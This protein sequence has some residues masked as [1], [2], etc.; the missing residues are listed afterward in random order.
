MSK[1]RQIVGSMRFMLNR[2]YSFKAGQYHAMLEDQY[3]GE[4]LDFQD[5]EFKRNS[6]YI[7][8]RVG[9]PYHQ[10]YEDKHFYYIDGERRKLPQK[11]QSAQ[12]DLAYPQKLIVFEM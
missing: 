4:V 12:Y 10:D 3:G 8:M 1:Q 9:L 6:S 11:Y 7:A 5:L 2:V